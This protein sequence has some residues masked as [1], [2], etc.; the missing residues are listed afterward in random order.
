[1]EKMI[2]SAFHKTAHPQH[3]G[4]PDLT[5]CIHPG[6]PIVIEFHIH[7]FFRR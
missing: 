2:L 5:V 6:P 3:A 7:L 4:Q 1:M